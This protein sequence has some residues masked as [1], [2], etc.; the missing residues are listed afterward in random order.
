MKETKLETK[1]CIL[2]LMNTKRNQD[3][4][5]KVIHKEFFDMSIVY[6]QILEYN[7]IYGDRHPSIG[8]S[9]AMMEREGVTIEKIEKDAY[10][11]S[12]REF[13]AEMKMIAEKH[14]M[15]SNYLRYFGAAAMLYDGFFE[16]AAGFLEESFYLFPTTIDGFEVIAES[17]AEP[18]KLAKRLAVWNEK[19][20][21]S[22]V[23]SDNIYYYDRIKKKFEIAEESEVRK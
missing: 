22:K 16:K 1:S 12:T 18:E 2:S 9:C 19:Q 21:D 20:A 10:I 6:R 13:P 17:K 3:F 7:V 5:E 4:L 23:L 11:V 15:V 8:I 14:Y